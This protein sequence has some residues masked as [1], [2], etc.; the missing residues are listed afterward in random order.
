MIL[1]LTHAILLRVKRERKLR[2]EEKR[3]TR[4]KKWRKGSGGREKK[5]EDGIGGGQG[6]GGGKGGERELTYTWGVQH[7]KKLHYQVS[8]IARQLKLEFKK[9]QYFSIMTEKHIRR[10]YPHFTATENHILQNWSW[11]NTN[12]LCTYLRIHQGF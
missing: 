12:Y 10:I 2:K 3:K 7:Q 6:W 4:T 1:K 5:K 11:T 9:I 8:P